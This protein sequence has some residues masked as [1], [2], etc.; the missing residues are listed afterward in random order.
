[1]ATAAS[2]QVCAVI[3]NFRILEL[4]WGEVDWRSELIAPPERF[5]KGLIQV[6]QRPGSG[7]RLNDKVATAHRL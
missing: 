4:Q 6:P 5:E 1:V 7:I 2:V 3:R